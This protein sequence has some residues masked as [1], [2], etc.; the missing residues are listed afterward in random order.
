MHIHE[1]V[2]MYIFIN[3]CTYTNVCLCMQ[4][5]IHEHRNGIKRV[6]VLDTRPCVYT[7]S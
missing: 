2:D 3:T 6:Y 5:C 1:H 4:A 7:S